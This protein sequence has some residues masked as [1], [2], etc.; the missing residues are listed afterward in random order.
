MSKFAMLD[1]F[2][3]TLGV[4]KLHPGISRPKQPLPL[5]YFGTA[6][7]VSDFLI[8]PL[9]CSAV[10]KLLDDISPPT[11]ILE[12]FLKSWEQREKTKTQLSSNGSSSSDGKDPAGVALT[13][14]KRLITVVKAKSILNV[15]AGLEMI[16]L[17]MAISSEVSNDGF[18]QNAVLIYLPKN[19]GVFPEMGVEVKIVLRRFEST[20]SHERLL[21]VLKNLV[22]SN[23]AATA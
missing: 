9:L 21:N 5:N 17:A 19:K 6:S 18:F 22:R 1:R 23:G 15:W 13:L 3:E 12:K 4:A 20:I 8:N 16:A 14:S 11:K 2:S 10:F 7:K